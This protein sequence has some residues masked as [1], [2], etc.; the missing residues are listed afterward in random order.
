MTVD[1]TAI[2][3]TIVRRLTGGRWTW[4]PVE[5]RELYPAPQG[6]VLLRGKPLREI[7]S[8]KSYK[9]GDDLMYTQFR[10]GA[11]LELDRPMTSICSG[12]DRV[13]VTYQ[14]GSPPSEAIQY[15]IGFLATELQK[16]VDGADDCKLPARFVTSVNRQGVSWTMLD[17]QDFYD[18]GR[19]GIPEI[20]II[21]KSVGVSKARSRVFSP[22]YPPPQRI[23]TT[24]LTPEPY[25]AQSFTLE[26]QL[27]DFTPKVINVRVKQGNGWQIL[28]TY[29]G[30][31]TGWTIEAE[32]KE[33]PDSVTTTSLTITPNDLAVGK[34]HVGQADAQLS[35]LFDVRLTSPGGNPLTVVDGVLVVEAAVTQ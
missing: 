28:I 23:S 31:V 26:Q 9:S 18:H 24:V 15:A 25:V 2:A 17:P 8:V 14:Y 6:K 35:G 20:D 29:P 13:D 11:L 4:P 3:T 30:D 32:F 27:V 16:A 10:G 33:E 7:V 1:Y 5:V 34:F 12:S 19:V 21:L 22:E